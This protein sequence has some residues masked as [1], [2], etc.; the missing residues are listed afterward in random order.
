MRP[1]EAARRE[2]E[3]QRFRGGRVL[4]SKAA[5]VLQTSTLADVDSGREFW[6]AQKISFGEAP[7]LQL[8]GPHSCQTLSASVD[9]E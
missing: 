6:K 1:Q 9:G 2:W 4:L 8:N 7:G 3:C 5:E